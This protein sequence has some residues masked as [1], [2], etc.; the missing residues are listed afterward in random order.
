MDR[1]HAYL[2]RSALAMGIAYDREAY[3]VR[4]RDGVIVADAIGL[5]LIA[6]VGTERA[7]IMTA[8]AVA[9]ALEKEDDTVGP[10]AQSIFDAI[11]ASGREAGQV[12]M[13]EEAGD[14]LEAILAK[15]E[16][17][18]DSTQDDSRADRVYDGDD[19]TGTSFVID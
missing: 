1:F 8:E 11:N 4:R 15:L 14:P 6:T 2:V 17:G 18:D 9:E 13:A 12:Y 7:E 19:P 16:Q 5:M 10:A 3:V